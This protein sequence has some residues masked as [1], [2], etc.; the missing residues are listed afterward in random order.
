MELEC[1]AIKR[2]LDSLRYYLLGRS[3]QLETNHRALQW[4]EKMRDSNSRFFLRAEFVRSLVIVFTSILQ[5][6]LDL[7][8]YNNNKYENICIINNWVSHL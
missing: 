4:L 5:T 2:A 1:L 7:N 3:F 8:N 6:S